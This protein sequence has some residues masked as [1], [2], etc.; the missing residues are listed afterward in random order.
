MEYV[1]RNTDIFDEQIGTLFNQEIL[2]NL[3]CFGTGKLYKLVVSFYVDLLHDKRFE[4]FNIS[5]SKTN[6]GEPTDKIYDILGHQLHVLEQMLANNGIEVQSATIKGEELQEENIIRIKLAEDNT[7]PYYRGRG[8]GKKLFKAFSIVPSRPYISGIASKEAGKALGKIY[9]DIKNLVRDNKLMSAILEID[10]TEDE[11]VLIKAFL[12]QYR[13]LWFPTK[14]RKE[15]LFNRLQE[16]II[17][18]CIPNN[19]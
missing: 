15:E 9:W 1:L 5:P 14:E 19:V 3:G 6:R 11:K 13:D 4:S 2:A 18:V 7:T 17:K 12:E 8:K 10:E 16:R